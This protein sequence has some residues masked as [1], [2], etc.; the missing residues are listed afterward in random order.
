LR[1]RLCEVTGP[2]GTDAGN[3]LPARSRHVGS[4]ATGAREPSQVREEAA[5]SGSAWVPPGRL[6]CAA[7]GPLLSEASARP[8]LRSGGSGGVR[9]RPNRH[10]WKACVGQLTVGSNPT[11][12]ASSGP[13]SLFRTR[14]LMW[15]GNPI[16]AMS[17]MRELN[18]T[19]RTPSH[20]ARRAAA[21]RHAH[22]RTQEPLSDARG[23]LCSRRARRSAASGWR[24]EG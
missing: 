19:D 5:L 14:R 6:A 8:P 23:G 20:R 2:D 15:R 3:L 12:S 1:Y 17:L 11:P 21:T 13:M 10:A 24:R 4:G 18:K 7:S 16:N 22:R 9:E